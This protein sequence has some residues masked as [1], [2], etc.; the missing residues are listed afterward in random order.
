MG[1]KEKVIGG[2]VVGF[3]TWILF[4]RYIQESKKESNLMK[5]VLFELNKREE[6]TKTLG[7]PLHYP[8]LSYWWWLR[9]TTSL[10]RVQG[11]VF[12]GTVEPSG[13][14]HTKATV[15]VCGPQGKC[16]CVNVEATKNGFDWNVKRI[17][18]DLDGKNVSFSY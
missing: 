7:F 9:P 17:D 8:T 11:D 13:K 6:V 4:D 15:A 14:T 3:G 1:F 10:G 18:V 2:G 12:K 16:G 5:T